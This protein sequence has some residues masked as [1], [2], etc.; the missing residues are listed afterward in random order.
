M[1]PETREV[2]NARPFVL[3]PPAP[4]RFLKML[5]V[6]SHPPVPCSLSHSSC[7]VHPTPSLFLCED[8]NNGGLFLGAAQSIMGPPVV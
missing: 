2:V 5:V 4:P 1:S 8:A 3:F 7:G 6:F